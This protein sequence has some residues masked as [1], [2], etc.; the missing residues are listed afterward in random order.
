[1]LFLI[2]YSAVQLAGVGY[3]LQGMTDN[4]IPFAVGVVIATILAIVFSFTAG[5][6]SVMW[7]DAL[8]AIVMVITATIVV[9]VV[10]H[11]LDGLGNFFDTLQTE[12]TLS[13][14]VPG[15]GYFSF[16]TFLGLTLPWFFFSLSN[17]QVSQRL[18][19]PSSL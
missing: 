6:R 14:S 18:F 17:P 9:F 16:L 3:L 19:M 5:I 13:L 10:I 12:H 8:Q 2:P 15:N 4:E 1:C 11:G 7:T